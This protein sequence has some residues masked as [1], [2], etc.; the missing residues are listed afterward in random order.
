MKV[1]FINV[2]GTAFSRHEYNLSKLCLKPEQYIAN[3]SDQLS[4][5]AWLAST[6]ISK[7]VYRSHNNNGLPVKVFENGTEFVYE[8]K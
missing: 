8:Y 4:S 6:T 1:V 7:A 5:Y 2:K 3:N